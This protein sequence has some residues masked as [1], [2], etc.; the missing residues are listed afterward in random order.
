MSSSSDNIV[1]RWNAVE[2]SDGEKIIVLKRRRRHPVPGTRGNPDGGTIG[3][4]YFVTADGEALQ[5]LT[6]DP[7]SW[8][9]SH[10]REFISDQRPDI[11]NHAR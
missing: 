3:R 4:D 8:R 10:G 9:D 5:L 2:V 1:A 6:N 7:W 11:G